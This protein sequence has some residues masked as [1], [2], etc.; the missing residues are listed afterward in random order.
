M[1]LK[2]NI[3]HELFLIKMQSIYIK[4]NKNFTSK[5]QRDF[6]FIEKYLET[7]LCDPIRGR[8]FFSIIIF[9]KHLTPSGVILLDIIN[10]FQ[11]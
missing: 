8:I 3:I 5:S 10:G 11:N 9:Y 6:M 4:M 7:M 2:Y 1:Y